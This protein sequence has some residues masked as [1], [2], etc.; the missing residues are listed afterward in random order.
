MDQSQLEEALGIGIEQANL[1][2]NDR[3]QLLGIGEMGI[4]NSTSAAALCGAILKIAPEEVVGR[5]TG[6][7][8]AGLNLKT[9]VVRD[10]LLLHCAAHTPLEWLQRVGGFEIAAMVGLI[11]EA[12]KKRLAVVV[13]GFI[14]TAAAVVAAAHNASAIDCCFFAH[15]SSETGHHVVLEKLA[16]KPLLSLGMRLEE[17]TGA[18]LAMQ[19]ISASAALL[20][21]M[22]TF[23]SAGVD[24]Q[25][26][27]DVA[28]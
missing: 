20:Q 17:G 7:D 12:S 9:R 10:A 25:N 4:G 1:A 24:G 21:K 22:A 2:V 23:E 3:V 26:L 18:A 14:A 15:C 28:L 16:V 13:D 6:V 5:G 19:L 8:D 11:L 27:A